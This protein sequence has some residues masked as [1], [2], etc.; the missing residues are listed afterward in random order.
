MGCFCW[1]FGRVLLVWLLCFL[2]VFCALVLLFALCDAG[3]WV[4]YL[5]GY[6]LVSLG[7]G[8]W[9][10][11]I[12]LFWF[13]FA[14]V[15]LHL[16]VCLFMLLAV[17]GCVCFDVLLLGVIV[18]CDLQ[19]NWLACLFSFIRILLVGLQR[20]WLW[21]VVGYVG[22]G[23]RVWGGCLELFMVVYGCLVWYCV[24]F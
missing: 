8:G 4:C 22:F 20:C 14:G 23:L 13:P 2:V 24:C 19:W 10:V 21:I 5:V 16:I 3:V 1:V 11:L 9:F 15:S 7:G 17:Y 12:A 18:G 6:L